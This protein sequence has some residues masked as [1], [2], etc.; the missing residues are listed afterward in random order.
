MSGL[1]PDPEM[2]REQQDKDTSETIERDETHARK[3][4]EDADKA[5][6][7]DRHAADDHAIADP[8]K[9]Q[10]DVLAENR[11]HVGPG[12]GALHRGSRGPLVRPDRSTL[13][14]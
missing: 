3:G 8:A 10:D 9:G 1:N 13:G 4:R 11:A 6:G 5:S 14:R 2:M 12:D 7:V